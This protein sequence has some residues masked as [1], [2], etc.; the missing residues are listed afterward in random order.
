MFHDVNTNEFRLN[1][2]HHNTRIIDQSNNWNVLLFKEA[3]HVKEKCPILNNCVKA[4]RDMQPFWLPF[5]YNVCTIHVFTVS[6]NLMVLDYIF[7][8]HI[9]C[10]IA[11]RLWNPTRVRESASPRVWLALGLAKNIPRENFQIC[12]K[13]LLRFLSPNDNFRVNLLLNNSN[14]LIFRFFW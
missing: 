3:Y 11:C 10:I 14:T 5:N 12:V 2:V 1:L 7:T 9:T 13:F 8:F 6:F 4:S